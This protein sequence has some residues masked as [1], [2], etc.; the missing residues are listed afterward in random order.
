MNQGNFVAVTAIERS[1]PAK[2]AN[3]DL[4]LRHRTLEASF[5]YLRQTPRTSIS[6]A[7]CPDH[8]L[9][10]LTTAGALVARVDFG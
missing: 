9:F 7:G 10:D 3:V 5:W 8:G 1:A 4:S 6:D 2:A